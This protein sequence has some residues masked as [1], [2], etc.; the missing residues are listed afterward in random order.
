MEALTRN[1]L[2]RILTSPRHER[3]EV[4]SQRILKL[5]QML[6]QA[7]APVFRNP[8]GILPLSGCDQIRPIFND[9]RRLNLYAFG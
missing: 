5:I 8:R 7:S 3:G 6:N 4:K 1:S 2:A 9:K